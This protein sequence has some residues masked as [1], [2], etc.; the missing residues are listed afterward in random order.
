MSRRGLFC[1][2]NILWLQGFYP[3]VEYLERS[4]DSESSL[5][6]AIL[7]YTRHFNSR[8]QLT[9]GQ[10]TAI[11]DRLREMSRDGTVREQGHSRVALLFWKAST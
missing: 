1:A 7:M 5:D 4:W 9:E 2:F 6:E 10:Q 11:A 8:G 3:E